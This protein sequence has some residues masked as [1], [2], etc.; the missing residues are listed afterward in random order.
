[1]M[2]FLIYEMEFLD[3]QGPSD[4]VDSYLK[5]KATFLFIRI[6]CMCIGIY[7][8]VVDMLRYH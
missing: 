8:I 5:S 6:F 4:L 3:P 7:S 1:M 2:S